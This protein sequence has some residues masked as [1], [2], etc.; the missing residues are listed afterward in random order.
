LNWGASIV[1]L[2][3][4]RDEQRTIA[5][6]PSTQSCKGEGGTLLGAAPGPRVFAG[7]A[8]FFVREVAFE[9]A[10]GRCPGG[11]WLWL[12]AGATLNARS[13]NGCVVYVKTGAVPTLRSG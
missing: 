13:A 3:H 8:E 12:P 11:T 10:E 4:G 2:V 1:T 7:G 5:R 9:Y 6:S